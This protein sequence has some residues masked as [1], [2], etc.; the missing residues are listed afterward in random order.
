MPP[1]TVRMRTQSTH[2]YAGRRL[3]SGDE[4]DCEEPHVSLFETLGRA[5]RVTEQR[6]DDLTYGTRAMTARR[7]RRAKVVQ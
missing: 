6:S 5:V 3:E 4:F 7:G 2:V 1:R